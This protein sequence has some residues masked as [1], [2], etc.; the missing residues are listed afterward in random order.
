MSRNQDVLY[1]LRTREGLRNY[2]F[3]NRW[4]TE[5]F[6]KT[7]LPED[8]RIAETWEVVDRPPE[9]SEILN[10]PLAGQTLHDVITRFGERLLGRD[11]V[12]RCGTRFPLLIKFLD[13]SN[14]LGEQAHHTDAQAAALGLPDPGKTEAWYMLYTR[15]GA[16]VH[17]GNRPGVTREDLVQALVEE[18]SR[19]L[20]VEREVEPG[21]A[22]LLYGG[23]MHYSRGGVLFYEIMENSD[24][25]I[26]LG[27][28]RE[29][30]PPEEKRRLAEERAALVHLE[31][32]FDCQTVPVSLS[33]GEN[34]RTFI[35]ACRHFALE[36]LDLGEAA[37][38]RP[39]GERFYVL[40][41]IDGACHVSGG[42][43]E[44][45]LRKGHTCLVPAGV[46]EVVLG[47]EGR[48]SVLK[49]YVPDLARDVV[50]P[51]RTAGV[52]DAAIVALGGRTRLNDLAPIVAGGAGA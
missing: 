6:E 7:G 8:H 48:A 25:I 15:P 27:R 31:D 12:A 29:P 44:V 40:S 42:G 32:G 52:S 14:V 41:C 47:P 17:M 18:R 21:D 22:F 39:E 26:P 19:E 50:E 2:T 46:D 45:V 43:E 35:L 51:L 5:V 16:T 28:F 20:M 11:I 34:R 4:I 3:G 36:R 1:P 13:A 30:L 23:T 24:V 9:S 33:S 37:T 10:G 49:A 38:L